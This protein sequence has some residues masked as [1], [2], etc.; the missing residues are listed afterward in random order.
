M[1]RLLE[2][3]ASCP[4]LS[5]VRRWCDA[6]ADPVGEFHQVDTY[7]RVNRGRLK[8]R[9]E[10]GKRS[11]TLIYYTR[12]DLPTP[13]HSEVYIIQLEQDMNLARVLEEALGVL[14]VVEKLRTIY[15]WGKVQIHLDRVFQLGDFVEF[16]RLVEMEEEQDAQAEYETLRAELH[17]AEADL[18][19]GSYSDLLGSSAEGGTGDA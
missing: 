19:A 15:R 4:D 12:E 1:W 11:T 2:L 8:I 5:R 14:V 13:K 18:V 9:E 16:E 17:V 10:K 3:K 6:N 7:F